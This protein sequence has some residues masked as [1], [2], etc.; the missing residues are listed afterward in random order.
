MRPEPVLRPKVVL[1]CGAVL[2]ATVAPAACAAGNGAE[3][4]RIGPDSV[5]AD[6]GDVKLRDVRLVADAGGSGTASLAAYILN[7]GGE[8]DTLTAVNL[9]GAGASPAPGAAVALPPGQP[10]LV[11]SP[12]QPQVQLPGPVSPGT[13]RLVGF[14]FAHAGHGTVNAY[15]VSSASPSA[16]LSTAPTVGP[17]SS[18]SPS[19]AP[20]GGAPTA[21]RSA[22]PTDIASG[23]ATPATPSSQ[24]PASP[25]APS[26]QAPASPGTPSSQP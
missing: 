6:I 5:N 2:L 25:S 15:V 14:T 3:T 4:Y 21:E 19:L 11:G 24:A 8:P 17:T 16:Q 12:G 9:E 1:R 7:P 22:R 18:A 23:A 26:S 20:G 13:Y 10:V